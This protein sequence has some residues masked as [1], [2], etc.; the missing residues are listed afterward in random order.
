MIMPN[1]AAFVPIAPVTCARGLD[2]AR[3]ALWPGLRH[4][5]SAEQR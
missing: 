5:L 1:E 2:T 4:D 3:R